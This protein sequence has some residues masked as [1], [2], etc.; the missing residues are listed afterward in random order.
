VAGFNCGAPYGEG[1][2]VTTR[3]VKINYVRYGVVRESGVKH[4]VDGAGD[5]GVEGLSDGT[6]GWWEWCEVQ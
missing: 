2:L 6:A 1:G 5:G 4:S 3:V